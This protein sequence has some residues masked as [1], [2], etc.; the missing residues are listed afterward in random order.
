MLVGLNLLVL[1]LQSQ[2][3][4][5]DVAD[6]S[7]GFDELRDELNY[8]G[9]D[10]VGARGVNQD[11]TVVRKRFKGLLQGSAIQ[12]AHLFAEFN[13]DHVTRDVPFH[14]TVH[15]A[16]EITVQDEGDARGEADGDANQ[17]I[18]EDDAYD[19]GGKGVKLSWP[20]A[21]HLLDQ[22]GARQ[23]EAG[24]DQDSGQAGQ[25]DQIE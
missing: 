12:K 24:D 20:A 18:R 25:G 6:G 17:E 19:R 9:I 8:V 7:S 3:R 16:T 11:V 14:H 4:N 1:T 15:R 22:L 13:A 10:E 23:F 21:P 5:L 2:H